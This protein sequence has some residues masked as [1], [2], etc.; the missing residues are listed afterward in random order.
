MS[1]EIY[2]GT[3]IIDDLYDGVFEYFMNIGLNELKISR[4]EVLKRIFQKGL[5]YLSEGVIEQM[6]KDNPNIQVGVLH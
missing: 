2:I 3:I 1:K 6:N 5:V 4:E